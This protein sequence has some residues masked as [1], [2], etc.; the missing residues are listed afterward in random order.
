MPWYEIT[1]PWYLDGGII[2]GVLVIV[3]LVIFKIRNPKLNEDEKA[4]RDGFH[5]YSTPEDK[6]GGGAS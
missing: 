5:I 2:T 4:F 6:A 3:F 1:L